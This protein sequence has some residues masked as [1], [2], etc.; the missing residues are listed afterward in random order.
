MEANTITNLLA[1][2]GDPYWYEW[3]VGLKF[4]IEMFD[5]NTAILGV[6]LQQS[7]SQSLD[8]VVVRYA[9]RTQC[10]QVK[11]SRVASDTLTFGD[12]VS[13]TADK[14]SLLGALATE[15]ERLDTPGCPCHPVLWTNRSSGPNSATIK[16]K[17]GNSW[18]RPPL[19][20][21][22]SL[23][24]EGDQH[25]RLPGPLQKEDA[26]TA[27]WNEFLTQLDVIKTPER[28]LDFLKKFKIL[29][30]QP[31]LDEIIGLQVARLQEIFGVTAEFAEDL[32]RD[33]R[34]ELV[35]WGTTSRGKEEE[36]DRQRLHDRIGLKSHR[37]KEIGNH[38]L[39]P[40]SPFFRSRA[41]LVEELEEEL[42]LGQTKVVFL[43]GP[44]GCGKTSLV[45]EL[46]NRRST[47][48]IVTLRYH[49]FKPLD[50]RDPRPPVI[51]DT[52]F[53][54]E[55]LWNDLLSQLRQ[56]AGANYPRFGIPVRNDFL[57][58]DQ[59]RG[60]VL[61]AGRL[62]SQE[63]K[64]PT[65]IAVD[66]LDHVAR[67]LV[68]PHD[69]LLN[70]LVSPDLLPDGVKFLIAG[71][72][73][74]DQYPDW[75]KG[76]M[77]HVKQFSVPGIESSDLSSFLRSR[78]EFKLDPEQVGERLAALSNHNTLTAMYLC[79][80]AMACQDFGEFMDRFATRS[81]VHD[82]AAYYSEIWRTLLGYLKSFEAFSVGLDDKLGAFLAIAADDM[83]PAVLRAVLG[84]DSDA[85]GRAILQRLHPLFVENSG[86][87]HPLHNDVKRYFEGRYLNSDAVKEVSSALADY[88]LLTESPADLR[89]KLLFPALRYATRHNELISVFSPAFVVEAWH[90]GRT[91]SEL[92]ET[93]REV[94]NLLAAEATLNFER[95]HVFALSC[96]TI[97]QLR[98]CMHWSQEQQEYVDRGPLVL[99]LALSSERRVLPTASWDLKIVKSLILDAVRLEEAGEHDRCIGL[100]QRWMRGLN[101][102]AVYSHLGEKRTEETNEDWHQL[103][104][105]LGQLT[106]RLGKMVGP[107]PSS[108]VTEAHWW[109]GYLLETRALDLPCAWW[110]GVRMLGAHFPKTLSSG[111]DWLFDSGYLLELG[112]TLRHLRGGAHWELPDR[113]KFARYSVLLGNKKLADRYVSAEIEG[114]SFR[115]VVEAKRSGLSGDH[116]D[117]CTLAFLYG[118]KAKANRHETIN[119]AIDAVTR[120]K[121][122]KDE[123]AWFLP[124]LNASWVIGDFL[125]K[126][127][128]QGGILE[129]DAVEVGHL[130]RSL[131]D[132]EYSSAGP[133]SGEVK[134]VAIRGLVWCA[135]ELGGDYKKA[136]AEVVSGYFANKRLDLYVDQM[137]WA[138]RAL[139]LTDS[140]E[141]Y[142]T[143]I[144]D[145]S[146]PPWLSMEADDRSFFLNKLRRLAGDDWPADRLVAEPDSN[147]PYSAHKD[148]STDTLIE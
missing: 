6:T 44:P 79:E 51:G 17:E 10:I 61:E 39:P 133:G 47:D 18:V 138:A 139:N 85:V 147:I 134:R 78:A 119:Q 145:T 25:S 67:S 144:S 45:S 35:H 80:E 19:D 111:L 75:L 30:A 31:G 84:L 76:H 40:P 99:P 57:S 148:Y 28:R 129:L 82:L 32:H 123:R 126:S 131:Q 20:E 132:P 43:S 87:F 107:I 130:M 128:D 136:A 11:H 108:R 122:R 125:R 9:D 24:A 4:L 146:A 5:E 54:A 127:R 70:S 16:D 49:A 56:I 93:A 120:S 97:L 88:L 137:L 69:N 36:V 115:D 106:A 135:L 58:A 22:I 14:P 3:C 116:M 38:Y 64:K 13:C 73:N 33:L 142:L 23:L 98:N 103:C 117:V 15:W 12:L 113:L 68:S 59:K 86:S 90:C 27:A 34:G 41:R 143:G 50:P 96:K 104:R 46:F 114:L 81:L 109:D 48:C 53:R 21:F 2:I 65:V 26:L 63:S 77:V 8:D 66:G 1:G 112:L 118:Y 74:Y 92:T 121:Y 95:A 91:F 110:R 60:L 37:N 141:S 140:I 105:H 52:L 55:T 89:H 102:T 29:T 62:L 83:R 71:Q 42:G 101:T 100:L 7:T 72:P 124:L 94:R